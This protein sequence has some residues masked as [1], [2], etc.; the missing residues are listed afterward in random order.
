[1]RHL[2]GSGIDVKIWLERVA[3]L[4][5]LKSCERL[6]DNKSGYCTTNS[7]KTHLRDA[8]LVLLAMKFA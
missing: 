2:R 7:A 8:L 3:A 1:M 4:F 6:A 5:E